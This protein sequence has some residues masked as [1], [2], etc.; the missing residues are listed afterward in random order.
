MSSVDY[1][2]CVI[3]RRARRRV[4]AVGLHGQTVFHQGPPGE[5]VTLQLGEPAYLARAL[6][7][8]VVSNFRASDLAEG[9]QGAPLATLF[10]LK[11]FGRKSRHV[12]VQTWAAS[13]M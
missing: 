2:E 3:E 8:P 12:C 6:R 10:H 11:V 4:E 13:G 5:P 9:G 1:A 7:V